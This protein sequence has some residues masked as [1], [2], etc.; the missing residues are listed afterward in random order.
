[1]VGRHGFAGV[2][3]EGVEAEVVVS[4]REAEFGG[5]VDGREDDLVVEG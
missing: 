2:P 3:G 4:C 5:Q 1:M